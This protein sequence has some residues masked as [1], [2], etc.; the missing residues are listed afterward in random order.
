MGYRDF[1]PFW[2]HFKSGLGP[3]IA[4]NARFCTSSSKGEGWCLT[5]D[6]AFRF[7][8]VCFPGLPGN[9]DYVC[10]YWFLEFCLIELLF[11]WLFFTNIIL[12]II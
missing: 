7:L 9:R 1:Y 8:L 5:L 11:E 10:M 2:T 6:K 4:P 3:C 12:G